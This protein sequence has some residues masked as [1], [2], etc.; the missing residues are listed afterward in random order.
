MA[1]D[2]VREPSPLIGA[3]KK[4]LMRMAKERRKSTPG[5]FRPS[6]AGS[7]NRQVFYAFTGQAVTNPSKPKDL[8]VLNHG[9]AI[10]EVLHAVFRFIYGERY[11][12]EQEFERKDGSMKGRIDGIVTLK[13]RESKKPIKF[14]VEFKSIKQAGFKK[15]K[16][17]PKASHRLQALIYMEEFGLDFMHV[18]YYNK[19]DE[20]DD[21]EGIQ[22]K[23]F[24]VDRDKGA[25]TMLAN[26]MAIVRAAAEAKEPPVMEVSPLCNW[27]DF[28]DACGPNI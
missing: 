16:F 14:G 19:N 18:I 15:L 8:L 1:S 22:L 17:D 24:R 28:K 9:E 2:T 7:C 23:E 4:G 12:E 26:K 21:V 25:M 6:S 11:K 3:I 13:P 20:I 27:C 5:R 10:H